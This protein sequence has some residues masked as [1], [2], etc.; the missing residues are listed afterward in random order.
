MQ[1]HLDFHW[2]EHLPC[3]TPASQ[4]G[5]PRHSAL[6]LHGPE[7]CTNWPRCLQ[8]TRRYLPGCLSIT[9]KRP[10]PAWSGGEAD[11]MEDA[12]DGA[13]RTGLMVASRIGEQLARMRELEQRTIAA[14]EEENPLS[15]LRWS[16]C[17]SLCI[18]ANTGMGNPEGVAEI[19]AVLAGL[20]AEELEEITV[21]GP[22]GHL[23]RHLIAVI[24]RA[25]RGP[26][27]GRGF[28]V[29]DGTVNGNGGQFHVLHSDLSDRIFRVG[30]GQS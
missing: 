3:L 13:M 22:K 24:D 5:T 19:S 14:A 12:V 26:D 4:P 23:G 20:T 18:Q 2:L 1:S 8:G 30:T 10:G 25:T 29:T 27:A 17:P 6:P 11:G 21:L 9:W 15:L 28:Y 16:T 7:R